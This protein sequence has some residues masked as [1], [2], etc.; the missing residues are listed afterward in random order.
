MWHVIKPVFPWVRVGQPV[1]TGALSTIYA[2]LSPELQDTGS[3]MGQLSYF[4]P[5]YILVNWFNTSRRWMWNPWVHVRSATKR[6]YE[7]TQSILADVD[8][9]VDGANQGGEPPMGMVQL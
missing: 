6:L 5:S 2:S 9:Q 4:G 8:K 1:K 7:E 3:T